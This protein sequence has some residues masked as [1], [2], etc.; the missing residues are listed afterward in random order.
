MYNVTS[1]SNTITFSKDG[2]DTTVTIPNGD[3]SASE[4]GTILSSLMGS[5]GDVLFMETTNKFSF[6]FSDSLAYSIKSTTMQRILGL[7]NQTPT[8]SGLTYACQ[9]IVDMGGVTNIY[10]RLRNLTMDNIDTRGTTTG[11]IIANVSNDTNFGSYIFFNPS[12]VLYYTVA[13]N[14]ISHLDLELTDQDGNLLELNQASYN[15]TLTVHFIEQRKGIHQDTMLK[16]I[17]NAY[18]ESENEEEAKI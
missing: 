12:E 15:L 5:I 11:N 4:L 1:R 10:I 7:K 8:A 13:E 3:Y 6:V 16:Q 2:I 17:M 14:S 9:G 18:D